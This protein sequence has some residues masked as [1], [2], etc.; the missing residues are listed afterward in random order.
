MPVD[1]KVLV[2]SKA[3]GWVEGTNGDCSEFSHQGIK[4]VYELRA[5]D[6]T[7][8]EASDKGQRNEAPHGASKVPI[9]ELAANAS[10]LGYTRIYLR[11]L[12][13]DA[14]VWFDHA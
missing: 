12:T 1:Q 3:Q 2:I 10:S 4:G 11:S 9:E 13:D 6:A 14:E 7:P 5:G 8:P